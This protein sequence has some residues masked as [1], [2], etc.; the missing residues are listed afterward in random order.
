M[1]KFFGF[2]LFLDLFILAGIIGD[3][4]GMI[5]FSIVVRGLIFKLRSIKKILED[6]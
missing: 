2:N 1:S 4:V 6:K 3:L 5:E